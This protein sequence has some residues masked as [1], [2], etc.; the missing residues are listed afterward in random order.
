METPVSFGLV[1]RAPS[2]PLA[3]LISRMAGFREA[4]RGEFHQRETASLVVPLIVSFGTPFRIAY[5][6]DPRAEDRRPSFAA[7]LHPGPVHI[8][9]DGGAE[10]VQVDFTPLGAFHLFGGAMPELAGR[11]VDIADVFGAAGRRLRER[12]GATNR[13]QVRFALLEA[14]IAAHARHQ[15]SPE[16]AFAYHTLM[17]ARGDARITSLANDIGW[18]RK[19]FVR[20]FRGE[21]GLGP[22]SVARIMRFQHACDLA[23]RRAPG[24]WA[25]IAAQSGYADQAHL[26]REFARLAGEPPMAWAR[27]ARLTEDR[28]ARVA[29]KEGDW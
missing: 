25:M 8:R 10:C 3:G 18:S 20:R 27:R 5:D 1:R 21:I 14:F 23:R 29:G 13:W 6:R 15:P 17:G 19:H 2:P 7:G 24:G 11:I 4:A 26:I 16:I 12:L 22:K 9:S 28:L